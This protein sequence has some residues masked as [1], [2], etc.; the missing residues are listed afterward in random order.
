MLRVRV[1][2]EGRELVAKV[3]P[4]TKMKRV[5][6]CFSDYLGVLASKL[7]LLVG[8]RE[9]G[10][11][12]TV[13]ELGMGE[14]AVVTAARVAGGEEVLPEGWR[15]EEGGTCTSL[16]PTT[17]ISPLGKRFNSARA[18]QA[19]LATSLAPRWVEEARRR[20]RSSLREQWGR[21]ELTSHALMRLKRKAKGAADETKNLRRKILLLNAE[22]IR[23]QIVEADK[24]E[25]ET[26]DKLSHLTLHSARLKRKIRLN[27]VVNF[28]LAN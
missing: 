19:F 25:S 26:K 9:V 27:P 24:I 21:G 11:L 8:G 3:L 7:R 12:E 22:K 2:G 28:V 10:D 6:T 13:Q 4:S 14:G 5:R 1:V 15:R 17:Y 23:R 20:W 16:L 18:V